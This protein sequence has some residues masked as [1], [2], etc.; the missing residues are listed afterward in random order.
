MQF[1]KMI[2]LK[3]AWYLLRRKSK[4]VVANCYES[5]TLLIV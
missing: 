5:S 1:T 2:I 4:I 3:K